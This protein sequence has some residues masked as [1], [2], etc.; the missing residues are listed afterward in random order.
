M[1]QNQLFTILDSVESTNNY[2]MAQVH[3]GLAMHGQAWFAKEQ[4]GG[5]GQRGKIWQSA[6]GENV[7]LS[8][9]I[10]PHKAFS[11][12]PYLL[13]CMVSSICRELIEEYVGGDVKIK[14][15]NDIYW[16]DRKAAGIL[17]ENV[18]KGKKWEW[19]I[20]GIGVNINQTKFDIAGTNPISLKLITNKNNDPVVF[21]KRIQHTLL[22]VVNEQG[23]AKFLHILNK[24][25]YKAN[26]KV[27]LKKG[28]V[29][30]ET[31]IA[32]VNEYGQLLTKDVME[33]AFDVGEVEWIM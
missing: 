4:W 6:I 22:K 18:F 33:R 14:W 15:P 1:D 10:K 13:S 11:D 5:K 12:K 23:T 19:S 8:I 17:I 7:I 27:M 2:A 20:I 30:F 29:A 21:A 9:T 32:G 31:M 3:A 28:T 26:E 16:R 25:L 24:Y